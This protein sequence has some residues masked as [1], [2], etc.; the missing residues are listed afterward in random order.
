MK[1]YKSLRIIRPQFIDFSSTVCYEVNIANYIIE[2]Q[3]YFYH[4]C[5]FLTFYSMK[6]QFWAGL[7]SQ[8]V[9]VKSLGPIM[10]NF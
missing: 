3:M 9:L 7:G 6:N 8:A 1:A 2:L 4:R 5:L 10:S